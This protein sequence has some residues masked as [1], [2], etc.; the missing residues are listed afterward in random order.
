MVS[1]PMIKQG[2]SEADFT[3]ALREKGLTAPQARQVTNYIKNS[4]LKGKT[5]DMSGANPI[6]QSATSSIMKEWPSQWGPKGRLLTVAKIGDLT[7]PQLKTQILS[8]IKTPTMIAAIPK[9]TAPKI[10]P[11]DKALQYQIKLKPKDSQVAFIYT[12]GCNKPIESPFALRRIVSSAK[13]GDFI[14]EKTGSSYTLKQFQDMIKNQEIVSINKLPK[15][16]I[17]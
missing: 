10:R 11:Q 2:I 7:V 9:K 17:I 4:F 5:F 8:G 14:V 3:A 1:K 12:V 6:V 15:R 13:Q 16:K